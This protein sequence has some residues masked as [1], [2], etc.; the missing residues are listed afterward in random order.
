MSKLRFSLLHLALKPGAL[1]LNYTLVERGIRVAAA[2]GADWVITPELCISGYQFIDVIGTDWIAVHPDQWTNNIRQ[3]AKALELAILF[4]HVERGCDDK[5]YNCGFI[6]D[7]RGSI[8][9]H[10]RKIN[11]HAEYWASPGQGTE[12]T[13]WQ[14]LKLGT[15]ICAD[16]YTKEIACTLRSKGAQLLLSP[17]AWAPGLYGPEGE[18]EQRTV[19]TGLPLIVCNR[20]GEEKTLTFCGAETLVIKHGQ[21]LLS[22]SSQKSAVLTFDWSLQRMS[23]SSSKFETVYL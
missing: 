1:L 12:P 9:G 19:E 4:G 13:N 20:T 21:R 22:H 5:F 10:H 7:A 3:L 23:P 17:A 6:V 15:M 18:W 11:T 2:S 14:G 8:I 16:A